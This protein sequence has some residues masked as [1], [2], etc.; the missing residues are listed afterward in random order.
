MKRCCNLNQC[1][2][3]LLILK[4]KMRDPLFQLGLG[5]GT[6]R[7]TTNR[8][9]PILWLREMVLAS[10]NSKSLIVQVN[11]IKVLEPNIMHPFH[12]LF[13]WKITAVMVHQAWKK[14]W[15][16]TTP[17]RKASPNKAETTQWWALTKIS[18]VFKEQEWSL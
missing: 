10:L 11:F 1:T 3:S 2:C 14:A 15:I 4:I 13:R 6:Y 16:D 12:A 18:T 17:L 8:V 9:A 5:E 7:F